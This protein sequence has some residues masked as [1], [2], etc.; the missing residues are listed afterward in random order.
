M[1]NFCWAKLILN[2]RSQMSGIAPSDECKLEYAKIHTSKAFWGVFE[3]KDRK[4]VECTH[5]STS[6]RPADAAAFAAAWPEVVD[7][8]TENLLDAS[9]YIVVEVKSLDGDG[10][11]CSKLEIISWCPD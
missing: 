6:E 4:T 2:L 8:V 3:I 10:K 1:G 7:Y 5:I 11:E 9:A